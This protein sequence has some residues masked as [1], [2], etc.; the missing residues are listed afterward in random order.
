MITDIKRKIQS[1]MS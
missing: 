1:V